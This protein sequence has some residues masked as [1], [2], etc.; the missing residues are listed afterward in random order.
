MIYTILVTIVIS[1]LTVLFITPSVRR[2]LSGVGIVARDQQKSPRPLLPTSAGMLVL[3]GILLGGFFFMGIDS[4]VIPMDINISLLLATYCSILIITMI[5]FLDDINIRSK[6]G[7]DK[8]IRDFRMGL[9]QWQKPLL[10]LLAAIPLMA[11]RAGVSGMSLPF[12]GTVEFGVIYPLILVPLAVV[13]VSNATN[14]LAGANGLEAGLGF[15]SILSLGIYSLLSGS[16]EASVIA[17]TT[18]FSLLAFLVFNWYPAKFLPGD[19]LTYLVGA[20]FVSVVIVGNIEK[21]GIIVF[22]PWMIEFFLKLRSR[23]SARSLGKL[24]KDGTLRPP[25]EK[26]YSL[27]HLVMKIRPMKERTVTMLILSLELVICVLALL[28]V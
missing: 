6:P 18:A 12:I 3:P 15:I 10:T 17:F 2:F 7:K 23:F 13:V 21:F 5:G 1:F 25:Y 14:M 19:S 4:F 27:N 11:M 20:S 26:I 9:R 16:I 28:F 22:I 8:G 24:R